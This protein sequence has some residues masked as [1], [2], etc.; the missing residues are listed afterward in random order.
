MFMLHKKGDPSDPAN[1]RGL[2][3]INVITKVFTSI[4]KK[5]IVTWIERTGVLPEE[6]AG[7]AVDQAYDQAILQVRSERLL[8]GAFEVTEGVL[9][10]EIL[11]PILFIL[12]LSDIVDFF[13]SR[14]ALGIQINNVYDLLMLLYAD[15]LVILART[16]NE[17]KKS[18][19][20]LEEY[21]TCNFLIVNINKT[22]IM[23]FRRGGPRE[24][25]SLLLNGKTIE[26]VDEYIY[27]GV[28]FTSS[29]LGLT[30]AKAASQ[31][32]QSAAGAGLATLAN[33]KAESWQ[34]T[35]R[36][37]D[38]IVAS[39]LLYASHLWGLRYL[40]LLEKSQLSFFKRLLLLPSGT[41]SAA[42]KHE[43]DMANVKTRV[44]RSA[45]GWI[46]KILDM[47]DHRI[48]KIF[49][50]RLLQL[51]DTP[52]TD[53][54]YNWIAQL[55]PLLELG[56]APS[57]IWFSHSSSHW[58]RLTPKILDSFTAHLR[59]LDLNII[60]DKTSCQ[61]NIPRELGA[62]TASYLINS[63]LYTARVIAQARLANNHYYRFSFKRM[64]FGL[65]PQLPCSIC[66]LHEKENL[67]HIF[68]ICPI[69]NP[70]RDHFLSS[71]LSSL[72][73]D[74]DDDNLLHLHLLYDPRPSTIPK[75][76][77]RQQRCVDENSSTGKN[78]RQKLTCF[79][80]TDDE[81]ITG[82]T[83]NK[84]ASSHQE[85][86]LNIDLSS[87]P[88]N[89]NNFVTPNNAELVVEPPMQTVST[90]DADSQTEEDT[91]VKQLKKCIE[92]LEKKL[93][94][95]AFDVD[96]CRNNVKKFKYY[97]GLK[98][99]D[100]D[101]L[102]KFLGPPVAES[103]RKW[104][105]TEP[106]TNRESSRTQTKV[107]LKNQLFLTKFKNIRVIIDCFEWNMQKS[108]NFNQQGNTYSSYK[109]HNTVKFLVEIISTGGFCFLSDGFEG[110]ISDK[111]ITIKSGLFNYIKQGDSIIADR[112]FNLE[113]LCNK[114]SDH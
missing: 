99:E 53:L 2:A 14:E 94:S 92:C 19:K 32:A 22:K 16:I 27:L 28:P 103:L 52:S 57:T 110:R 73:P 62:P 40:D 45:L 58:K 97:T 11:S 3:M 65:D 49:Y 33:I 13:R 86:Q 85:I 70:Y 113:E 90:C 74:V 112:G 81:L 108:K 107:S 30:A 67:A 66:N 42:L 88:E 63:S 8:S 71:L 36:I 68:L 41:P 55:K 1:Y 23:H 98:P 104:L 21:C 77:K 12:Y 106:K 60:E 114:Q 37:F 43:L 83:D 64:H 47:G 109:S 31:K 39:T 56:N 100:F 105:T 44:L 59:R 15:D 20:I 78:K 48:P 76:R 87:E 54:K 18:L 79:T 84:N 24:K 6:Q 91:E 46:S 93:E 89:Y 82:Q 25:R 102:W 72:T 26:W 69:Y 75:D 95:E 35:L 96:S 9:Q 29:T 38:A 7:Q 34:G 17:L 50:N 10:G 101:T 5:R 4:I 80:A 51:S 61:V 111:E